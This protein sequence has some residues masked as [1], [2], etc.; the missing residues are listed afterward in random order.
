MINS[1]NNYKDY[2]LESGKSENTIYAYVTDVT[3]YLK[4]LNRKR[5][6]YIRVIILQ[7]LLTFKIF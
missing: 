1:I 2:L 4:F 6:I 5:L 7:W 3:L